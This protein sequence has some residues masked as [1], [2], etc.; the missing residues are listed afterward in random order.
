MTARSETKSN[1]DVTAGKK[2]RFFLSS[3][4][5]TSFFGR[6]EWQETQQQEC[7]RMLQSS[8]E[9]QNLCNRMLM[10]ENTNSNTEAAVHDLDSNIQCIE[11]QDTSAPDDVSLT[12][13]SPHTVPTIHETSDLVR[14]NPL[15]LNSKFC[16]GQNMCSNDMPKL[17]RVTLHTTAGSSACYALFWQVPHLLLELKREVSALKLG[18]FTS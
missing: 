4:N 17:P 6:T 1:W 2:T 8:L 12:S 9:N 5:E 18:K 10:S 15:S 14:R 11:S 16:L 13:V 7:L 3:Y